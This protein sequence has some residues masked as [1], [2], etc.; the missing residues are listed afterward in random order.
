M[1]LLRATLPTTIEI[2]LKMTALRHTVLGD[3][4]QIHQVLINLCTNAH[5]AML[6]KGGELEVILSDLELDAETV[7]KYPGLK[8]G[9]Y[10]RLAVIDTGHG[11]DREIMERIF[12]PY[13]TTKEKGV[14]TGLG[15]AV[16]HG[17][18][19]DLG[20]AISVDS[21]P[22]KG[23][24]FEV[25]LPL[26]NLESLPDSLSPD[27]VPR[28]YERILFVDDEEDLAELA[29]RMLEHMG[30]QAVVKTSSSQALETFKADPNYFDLII[31]DMTMPQMTGDQ[32]ATEIMALRPRM[33]VILCTGYNER[34]SE[35]KAKALGIKAFVMKPLVMREIARTIRKVL[36][37]QP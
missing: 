23:S 32:L 31:T 8:P 3:P 10:L 16:V 29:L 11:M 37:E 15:L 19:K 6:E 4:T 9:G 26:V 2:R 21:E 24:T 36:D 20:G 25:F 12:D 1:K 35:E 22:G 17:I 27:P 18:V 34:I 33:P 28:G 14:G 13:F 7:A 5:H 30:Y